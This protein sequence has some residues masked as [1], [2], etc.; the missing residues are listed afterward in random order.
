MHSLKYCFIALLLCYLTP[1]SYAEAYPTHKI[2][3]IIQ[4]AKKY[5]DVPY[6]WAGETA[7]GIDCSALMQTAFREAGIRIPRNSRAQAN[8]WK[9][10]TIEQSQLQKGDLLFFGSGRYYIGHVGLVTS[11]NSSGRV[12]FIH[13]SSNNGKV[14]FNYLEGHWQDLYRT[15]RRL[16][17]NIRTQE[18]S[19]VITVY[20]SKIFTGDYPIASQKELNVQDIQHLTPCQV[21]IMKNEI[22]ARH[23]YQFHKNPIMVQYF[24]GKQW[25]RDIPKITKNAS[26]VER[27]YM[28]PVERANVRLLSKKEGSCR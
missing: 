22:F 19:G 10:K 26:F 24:T 9:G 12:R 28:S 6:K 18:T 16:F 20:T 7:S 4:A 14:A 1:H 3:P 5:L 17:K 15:A 2:D 21:K 23:G 27:H 11:V 8:Y 25:Y 13:A